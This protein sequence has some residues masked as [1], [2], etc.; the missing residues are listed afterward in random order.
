[1]R[2]II[3]DTNILL[4]MIIGAVENGAYIKSSKRLKSFNME[5]YSII[6]N[7]L[8]SYPKKQ[9]FITPYI[10]TEVSNLIDLRSNAKILAYEVARLIF[11]EFSQ[12]DVTINNDCNCPYFS[13][14]GITDVSLI[15]LSS[16]YEIFTNDDKLATIL[17]KLTKNENNVISYNMLKKNSCYLS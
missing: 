10:A 2:K 4:L 5:D 17:Y 9:R 12:L 16:E 14:F 3:V 13:S 8:D 15:H 1:M 11:D 7:F 6:L